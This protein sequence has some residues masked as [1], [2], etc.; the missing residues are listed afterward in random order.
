MF[1][2]CL[3]FGLGLLS[4]D[5][6]GSDISKMATSRGVHSDDFS[7]DLCLQCPSPT[8]SHSHPLPLFTQEILQEPQGGLTQIPMGFPLLLWDLVH[9]STPSLCAPFKSNVPISSSPMELVCRS[10]TGPQH[11]KVQGLLFLMPDP[12][13]W[14]PDLGLRTLNPMGEPL[15]Y[16]YFPVCEPPTWRV[17]VAYTVQLPLLLSR[18]GLFFVFW[19]RVSFLIVCSLFC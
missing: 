6:W 13:L 12:Q 18:F 5:E 17:W 14:D 11:Q 10:P 16:C 1:R 19:S 3:L 7:E 8:T 2:P 9:M 4:P 15:R